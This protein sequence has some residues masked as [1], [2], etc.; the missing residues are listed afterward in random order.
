MSLATIRTALK[1]KLDAI[2]GVENVYDYLYWTED[3]QTIYDNF[4]KDSRINCWFIGLA[5]REPS[6]ITSGI[7]SRRRIFDCFAYYSFKSED[8]TS[9]TFE[10]L[11]DLVQNEFEESLSFTTATKHV[12]RIVT[13]D[14]TLFAGTPAHRGHIQIDTVEEIAQDLACS[15]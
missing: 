4:A 14:T 13:V 1:T 11:L 3:W 8:Q 2:T 7:V 10:N 12:V 9:I 15:G 6:K 5:N